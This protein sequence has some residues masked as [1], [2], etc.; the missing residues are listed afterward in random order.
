MNI[1]TAA[2]ILGIPEDDVLDLADELGIEGQ[3]TIED[4]AEMAEMLDD[5]DEDDEDEESD[6][7]EDEDE[8]G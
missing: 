6:E 3:P 1:E 4:V 7:D 2:T 5:E 8:G